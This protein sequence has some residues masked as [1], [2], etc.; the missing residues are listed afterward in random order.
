ME[1]LGGMNH[2]S[3]T[4]V[5]EEVK[6]KDPTVSRA[7]VFRILADAAGEGTLLRL[8]IPGS[9]DRFDVTVKKHCH[10]RCRVCERVDDVTVD[11]AAVKS[12]AGADAHGYRIECCDVEFI[13]LCP[14]CAAAEDNKKVKQQK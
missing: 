9:D 3:A 5:Y 14:E 8:M 10:I 7:T 1:T 13:G 11:E 6:R 4:A 2:P 12:L